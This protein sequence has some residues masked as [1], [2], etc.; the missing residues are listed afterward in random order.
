MRFESAH[1]AQPLSSIRDAMGSTDEG[2][3]NSRRFA[4]IVLA[5]GKGTRMKSD[6]PKVMHPLANRPLVQHVLA[7]LAPLAAERTVVVVAPG[8]DSV[9]KAVAPAVTAIQGE[10][11]GTGHATLAG[12]PAIDDLIAEGRID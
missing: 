7:A 6:L 11:L 8:M 10:A 1:E 3:M 9:A 4:A 12:C 5:A 2:A